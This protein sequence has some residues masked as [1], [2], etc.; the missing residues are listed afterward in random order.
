MDNRRAHRRY[1]TSLSVEVYTGQDI[2]LAVANNL[3]LGGIGIASTSAVPENAV[4]GLSMFLVE[5]GI[6]DEQT[7]P[8]NLRAQVIWCAPSDRGGFQAGLKFEGL[9]PPHQQAISTFLRRLNA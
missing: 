3:S 1:A 6:E 8:L 4:V 7:E 9:Q 2:I 5:D